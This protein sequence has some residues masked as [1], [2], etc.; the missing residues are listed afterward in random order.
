MR[1][2]KLVRKIHLY[3]GLTSGMVVF[4]ISVTGCIYVFEKELRSLIYQ[5]RLYVKVPDRPVR[6]PAENLLV[7]AKMVLQPQTKINSLHFFA[8]QNRS[9][10]FQ[11]YEKNTPT[12]FLYWYGDEIRYFYRVY[13]DPYTGRVLKIENTKLEFFKVIESLHTSLLLGEL[14]RSIIGYAVLS[15][16]VM[17]VTGLILWWPHNSK[18]LKM[19]TWF[20]WKLTTKWKRKNYDVHNILG[21]YSLW[22][23]LFIA[24]TGL[25]WSFNWVNNGLQW[26]ANGGQK[27]DP[28]PR[29]VNSETG[30]TASSSILNAIYSNSHDG[31]TGATRYSIIFPKD[32]HGTYNAF[33]LGKKD[34]VLS[35]T[36]YDK[37]TGIELDSY[38]YDEMNNGEQLRYLNYSIHVGSILGL[39]GQLL[40]FF[41]SLIS[42]SLPVTGFIIWYGRNKKKRKLKKKTSNTR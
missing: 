2:K 40:A 10:Y 12:R 7:K 42:A 22:I 35:T 38:N 4:V 26:L 24:I 28:T 41:A 13:L 39:P 31:S 14:G 9:V 37:S 20:R 36:K 1:T 34:I 18:S 3:L 11:A 6:I 19:R 29:V 32:T 17:L 21:F 23:S 27:L 8:E 25:V 30:Q 16:V 15:F 33:A 5:D